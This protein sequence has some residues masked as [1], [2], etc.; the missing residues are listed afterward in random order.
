MNTGLWNMDSGLTALPRPGMTAW[1]FCQWE[2]DAAAASVASGS[3]QPRATK[4]R[5]INC[6]WIWL[7][8]SQICVI[9][10]SRNS[11]STR[12]SLM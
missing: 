1:S 10:A 11:R 2:A 4:L 9:L 7:V 12:Y 6:R 3:T 5:P 8:P